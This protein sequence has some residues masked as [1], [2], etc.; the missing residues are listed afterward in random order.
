[1]SVPALE[2]GFACRASAVVACAGAVVCWAVWG[3]SAAA[4]L[5][6][7]WLAAAGPLL[8][9]A[10]F[11]PPAATADSSDLRLKARIYGLA[12]VKLPFLVVLV[13]LTAKLGIAA[14][15]CFVGGACSVYL[16]LTAGAARSLR[17]R[18]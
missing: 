15:G 8:L 1:V 18:E 17:S 10:R 16:A 3:W 11:L 13:I 5:G 7:G 6:M 4:G 14:A 2:A 9:N 12:L